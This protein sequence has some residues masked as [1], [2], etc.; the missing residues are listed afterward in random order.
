ESHHFEVASGVSDMVPVPRGPRR[1]PGHRDHV[2]DAGGDL[3][4]MRLPEFRFRAPRTLDDALATLAGEGENARLLA[5]GTDLLPN[6]KRRH[7][8]ASTLVTLSRL[9]D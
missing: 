9:E 8:R 5:G 3:E 4:M 1:P 7:Q 2:R 6:L